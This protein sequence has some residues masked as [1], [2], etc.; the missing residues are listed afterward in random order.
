[1]IRRSAF[2]LVFGLFLLASSPAAAFDIDVDGNGERD[3]LTDGLLALRYLF[4]FTGT[5][6]IEGAVGN[7][8]TRAV[9]VQ[10]EA[11][12]QTNLAQLDIDDDDN[13][14]ALT[15]G[16]LVLRYLFGFEG[17]ALLQGAISSGATRTGGTEIEAYIESL[18]TRTYTVTPVS[19]FTI[20]G[21]IPNVTLVKDGNDNDVVLLVYSSPVGICEATSTDGLTFSGT[22]IKS[23]DLIRVLDP[24]PQTLYV[25]GVLVRPLPSGTWRYFIK[26][27]APPGN[28]ERH[29]YVADRTADGIITLA[30]D[31]APVYTG[32]PTDEGRVEVIDLIEAL[33]G[34]WVMYYV[35]PSSSARNSRSA[36]SLDQGLS[37]T[38]HG[39]NPF[40]DI[41]L[42]GAQ[43]INVDPA[44]LRLQDD[45]F[46]A[47]TMRAAMLYFWN[48]ADGYV[49]EEIGGSEINVSLWD[50][51]EVDDAVGL[52]DPTLLQ[53]P[54]GTIYMYVTAGQGTT[55]RLVA[56]KI[57]Y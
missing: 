42:T 48:S 25:T 5:T 36:T 13:T 33:A 27:L 41:T 56:A 21:T 14:D 23:S 57:T 32:G 28:S 49:W 1:M 16:L 39:D 11:Y 34:E 2:V 37:W 7:S 30:N 45:T 54:D 6:L 18:R 12:L 55:D 20:E 8:A 53:L 38:F 19:G 47:V 31:H 46:I 24:I 10:I 51:A 4:G 43:N 29:I 35:A 40:S 44:V 50:A 15:D 17:D 9:A 22:G 26:A 52:F 3:A